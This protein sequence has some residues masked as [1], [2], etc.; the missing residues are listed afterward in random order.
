LNSKKPDSVYDDIIRLLQSRINARV[1]D[2]LREFHTSRKFESFQDEEVAFCAANSKEIIDILKNNNYRKSLSEYSFELLKVYSYSKNQFLHFDGKYRRE[3]IALYQRL[4]DELV[5][6]LENPGGVDSLKN[7]Y[8]RLLADHQNRLKALFRDYFRQYVGESESFLHLLNSTVSANYSAQLQLELLRIDP[9]SLMEPV[10]DLG[11][12]KEGNLVNYL[13]S[14][15]FAAFGMDRMVLNESEYI[16]Q[17]DWMENTLE[18]NRWGTI[19]AHHSFSTNFIYQHY[20]SRKIAALYAKKYM[21]ILKSLRPGGEFIYTP[22]LPF[23]EEYIKPLK[24]FKF[25][26]FKITAPLKSIENITY[27]SRVKRIY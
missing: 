23:F 11:C 22:G 1:D 4:I 26:S 3:I 9:F 27:T 18:A 14:L 13:R 25:E 17:G 12:G 10:L 24:A 20:S 15:G 7:S 6:V 2:P 16:K 8:S 21:E 19:I 5:A